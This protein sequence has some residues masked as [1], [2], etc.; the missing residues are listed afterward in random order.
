MVKHFKGQYILSISMSFKT[1]VPSIY[2]F[3]FFSSDKDCE[4]YIVVW[5]F[6]AV[7]CATVAVSIPMHMSMF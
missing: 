6:D 7:I 5:L 3:V 4:E 2:V 1:A